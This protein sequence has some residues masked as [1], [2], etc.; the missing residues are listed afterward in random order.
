MAKASSIARGATYLLAAFPLVVIAYQGFPIPLI[1]MPPI[2]RACA[3]ALILAVATAALLRREARSI[4]EFGINASPRLPKELLLG[5][6]GGVL[7]FATGAAGLRLFLPFEWKVN[8][9]IQLPLIGVGALYHLTTAACEE[10][11]W[12]GYALDGLARGLGRWRAQ[13]VVALVAACFHVVCGWSWQVALISTTAGSLLFG[14]VFLRW[15]SVPAA[16]GV[17]AAWNW[18]R[19]LIMT[20]G[21]S[22]ALA[23]PDGVAAW[24]AAQWNVAQAILVAVTLGAAWMVCRGSTPPR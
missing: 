6:V 19:D 20:P 12:R 11:A 15:R 8:P 18:T 16:V 24:T 13:L 7:L 23:F 2:V 21:G 14:C 1:V 5:F 9:S 10:L 4:A 22:S 3:V 17:H